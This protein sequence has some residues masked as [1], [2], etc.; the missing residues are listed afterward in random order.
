MVLRVLRLFNSDIFAKLTAGLLQ[1][2]SGRKI[3]THVPSLPGLS[4][5]RKSNV[6]AWAHLAAYRTGLLWPTSPSV[7]VSGL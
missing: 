6:P 1:P 3:L 4:V 7:A 5:L 2:D